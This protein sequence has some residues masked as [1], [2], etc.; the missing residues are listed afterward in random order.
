MD[1]NPLP[2]IL[3]RPGPAR[4]SPSGRTGTAAG[5]DGSALSLFAIPGSGS[6]K[7]MPGVGGT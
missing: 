2:S 4:E 7:A 3:S 1:G 6:V 5:V